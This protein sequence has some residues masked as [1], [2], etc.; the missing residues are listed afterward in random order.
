M[1][2]T[3]AG[4]TREEAERLLD[5]CPLHAAIGLTLEEWEPGRAGFRFQPPALVRSGTAGGVHGGALATALDTAA[6][7]AAIARLGH[8]CSTVD[9]RTDFLR[10]AVDAGFV[11]TGELRRAG[12]R[13]AWADATLR[14]RDERVVATGRGV[15]TW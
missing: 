11:V 2:D 13:L 10:P 5:E 9:L 7:F 15:F 3:P 6:C 4:L 8:D 12:R 1:S 14:T